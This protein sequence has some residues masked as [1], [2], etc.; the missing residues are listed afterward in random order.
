LPEHAEDKVADTLVTSTGLY[1]AG[2]ET[3]E[4]KDK[5]TT[6][7]KQ[8]K[9]IEKRRLPRKTCKHKA[10][11]I[12]QDYAFIDY[13]RD[14]NAWGV[15]LETSQ[16]IRVGENITMTIPLPNNNENIKIIGKIVRSGPIGVGIEFKMGIL[17]S[18]VDSIA[19]SE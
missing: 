10:H 9:L 7:T 8:D 5:M 6:S 18:I 11:C 19:A 14:I 16:P 4:T 15:L 17:D 1:D 13:I 2:P 3:K 12:T